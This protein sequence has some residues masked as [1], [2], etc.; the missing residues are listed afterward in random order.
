MTSSFEKS[1]NSGPFGAPDASR[2]DTTEQ[3]L[4]ISGAMPDLSDIA[5]RFRE[6]IIIGK[7]GAGKTIYLRALQRALLPSEKLGSSRGTI[8]NNQGWLIHKELINLPTQVV[9]NVSRISQRAHAQLVKLNIYVDQV[10][11]TR[12]LWT[13]IWNC[14]ILAS[15][16]KLITST[17]NQ[18]HFKECLA[19]IDDDETLSEKAEFVS[20]F[21]S[22][23]PPSYSPIVM[24]QFFLSK[25]TNRVGDITDYVES[26][27]WSVLYELVSS[28]I[29]SSPQIAIFIDAIDDAFDHAPEAWLDCQEGLFRS[30]FGFLNRNDSFGGRVHVIVALREIVYSSLLCSEHASRYL[31]DDHVRYI[32]WDPVSSRSFLFEKIMRLSGT[33]IANPA[34]DSAR[35]PMRYWIGIDSVKNKKRD[36]T[37]SAAD[38]ILRHTRLLPRDIVLM[39]NAICNAQVMRRRTGKSFTEGKLRQ[40]VHEVAKYIAQEAISSA[41]NEYIASVDYLAEILLS[42]SKR[43]RV[44]RGRAGSRRLL[45]AEDESAVEVADIVRQIKGSVEDR[46]GRFFA[47]VGTER[48]DRDTLQLALMECE[49]VDQGDFEK[50][51]RAAFSRFDNIL[52]RHGLLAYEAEIGGMKRWRFSWRGQPTVENSQLPE[53]EQSFGFH[54]CVLD[55]YPTIRAEGADP[56]S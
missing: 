6:R 42:S 27:E 37:E 29:N 28:V 45:D 20:H 4:A 30:V 56:V 13:Q 3:Y 40:V 5:G 34:A 23:L 22:E 25:K 11:R 48:F 44:L 54:S 10:A 47:L 19:R 50:S 41:V 52:Y 2:S 12:E 35:N 24:I 49:L 9:I 8:A 31:W 43:S 46:V 51:G 39:G 1:W 17:A 16:Y 18:A 32:S 55:R 53:N 38:Y 36:V 7:K 33:V 26:L 15:T 14:A 21:V